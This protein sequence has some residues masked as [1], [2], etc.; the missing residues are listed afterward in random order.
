MAYEYV[1]LRF[2]DRSDY[3]ACVKAINDANIAA[4]SLQEDLELTLRLALASVPRH[5]S[6]EESGSCLLHPLISTNTRKCRD[7]HASSFLALPLAVPS[8]F[9]TR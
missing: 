2:N 8:S 6:P 4:H 9:A 5:A 1:K 7:N 3:L